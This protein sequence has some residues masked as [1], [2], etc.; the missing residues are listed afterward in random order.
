MRALYKSR[1]TVSEVSE[2]RATDIAGFKEIEAIVNPP[3]TVT[4]DNQRQGQSNQQGAVIFKPQ[5]DLKPR[6]LQR[7]CNLKE[8][9]NFIQSVINYMQTG[10]LGAIPN[11]SCTAKLG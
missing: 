1:D 10:Y 4:P 3:P 8:V 2:V 11:G 9:E 7:D 6:L 5:A